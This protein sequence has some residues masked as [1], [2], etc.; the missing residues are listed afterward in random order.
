MSKTALGDNIDLQIVC[1][2]FRDLLDPTSI[3]VHSCDD[4]LLID[5]V[6][7]VL[8]NVDLLK[9]DKYKL[10]APPLVKL[11]KATLQKEKPKNISDNEQWRKFKK[12]VLIEK[13]LLFK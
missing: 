7:T 6:I 2:A 3:Y 1:T 11:V 5:C 4:N 10:A 13:K 12:N 9:L 8:F